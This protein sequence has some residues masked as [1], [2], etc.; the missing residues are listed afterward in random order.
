[1]PRTSKSSS[2]IT[3]T[4]LASDIMGRNSL[5]G[6]DQRATR[7][8]RRAVPDVKQDADQSIMETLE[9]S[10]KNERSRADLNKGK[11]IHRRKP[12]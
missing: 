5:Q 6:D 2:A 12:R 9:K 3:Q 8:E 11:G 4:D 10:N 7:N 1:M